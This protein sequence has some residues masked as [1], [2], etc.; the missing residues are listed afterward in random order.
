[1]KSVEGVLKLLRT[2]LGEA[3]QN[4]RRIPVPIPGSETI[5]KS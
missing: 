3:D 2:E 5:Y 1:M 4:G